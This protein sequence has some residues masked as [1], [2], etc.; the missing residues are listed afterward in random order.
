MIVD[1]GAHE[2]DA[3]FIVEGDEFDAFPAHEFLGA[4]EGG[5]FA[6]DHAWD[7]EEDGGSRAHD[8]WAEGGD[9]GEGVPVSSSAGV[10]DAGDLGVGGGVAGLD[11]EVVS[12][13]DDLAL[14]VDE[15]RADGDPA[16]VAA[17]DGLVDGVVEPGGGLWVH[18]MLRSWWFSMLG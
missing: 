4:D 3:A 7:S 9:E 10:T 1:E 11:A 5:V 8:A 14:G 2:V 12:C 17:F 15:D 6:D 16:L 13:G 18:E